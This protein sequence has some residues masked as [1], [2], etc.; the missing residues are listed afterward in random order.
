MA[1][2]RSASSARPE[3]LR[4]APELGLTA[5]QAAER[6]S[7]GLSNLPLRSPGKSVGQI[8]FTNIFT[9]FNLV[10]VILAVLVAAVGS[11]NNLAFMGVVI[12]NTVIGIVQELR[13]KRVLD[14]LNLLS[15][16]RVTAVRDGAELELRSEE[17][18]RDDVVV[19]RAGDQICADAEVLTG[20]CRVNEALVTG[21]ADEI[22][23]HFP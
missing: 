14:R 9:Y 18:V 11:W 8:L 19:F 2:K 16:Q 13:S 6:A 1:A 21:E 5:E 15:A 23:K 4:P 10:F 22:T 17:L 7:A 12:C 20:S 3:P